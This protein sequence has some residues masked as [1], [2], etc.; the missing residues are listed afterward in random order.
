M[1]MIAE[2]RCDW[3]GGGR[4]A[5][6]QC[7][8]HD[9]E[10]SDVRS[11]SFDID[12]FLLSGVEST[13]SLTQLR[14]STQLPASSHMPSAS[15]S[16]SS[17]SLAASAPLRPMVPSFS[18]ADPN[19]HAIVPEP[20]ISLASIQQDSYLHLGGHSASLP[21]A[22]LGLSAL[23]PAGAPARVETAMN[24]TT[25]VSHP[26]PIA[27]ATVPAPAA[28]ITNPC[29][30]PPTAS[31]KNKAG[32]LSYITFPGIPTALRTESVSAHIDAVDSIMTSAASTP[33]DTP[34]SSS[35]VIRTPS[36]PQKALTPSKAKVKSGVHLSLHEKHRQHQQQVISQNSTMTY[37]STGLVLP[38]AWLVPPL[39]QPDTLSI[40]FPTL[41]QRQQVR[42]RHAYLGRG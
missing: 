6:E 37:F 42:D 30:D 34:G 12:R 40:Y 33:L 23:S 20:T 35:L 36:T 9:Q 8:Y 25:M 18:M 28:P 32:C 24:S 1:G 17:A 38:Q 21:S 16:P 31:W 39:H 3:K 22:P 10:G 29:D 5:H 27:P 13:S 19:A 11:P 41:E 15:F 26:T 2:V 4:N 7:M 14:P